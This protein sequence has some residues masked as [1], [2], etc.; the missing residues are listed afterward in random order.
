VTASEPIR[1]L[2]AEDHLIV[3]EG[4]RALLE[5]EPDVVVV[6]VAGNGEQAVAEAVRLRPD[7]VLMD[8]SM[9][10]I[11]GAE[12]TRQIRE[13]CP[14]TRVLVLSMHAA[15]AFVR[16]AVRAGAAGYVLKGAGMADLLAAVRAV[17]GGGAFFGA[18]VADVLLQEVAAPLTAREVEVLR[19]VASGF[20][21]AQIAAQM[22]LSS[23]TVEGHRA[24]VMAKLGIHDLP[25]LVRYAIR[26]G[27]VALYD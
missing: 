14:A 15:E 8:L 7:V 5:R 4:L 16:P 22:D 3:R 27:L 18:G 19:L 17:A 21:S 23:R 2:I 13:R 12:A 25:G 24:R 10:V 20:S 1:V 11:D 26:E 6:G 9:P